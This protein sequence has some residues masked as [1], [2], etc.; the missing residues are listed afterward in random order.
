MHN[1]VEWGAECAGVGAQRGAAWARGSARRRQAG[2]GHW[3][4]GGVRDTA[5]YSARCAHEA[6]LGGGGEDR[7]VGGE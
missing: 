1:A 2:D 7:G 5:E 4:R 3:V 6:G